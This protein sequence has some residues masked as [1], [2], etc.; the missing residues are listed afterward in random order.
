M[1]KQQLPSS[2]L[3]IVRRLHPVSSVQW[4]F[5]T[6]RPLA[7]LTAI[8]A[9]LVVFGPIHFALQGMAIADYELASAQEDGWAV[10]LQ[11]SGRAR[12]SCCRNA[13]KITLCIGPNT[14]NIKYCRVQS[15]ECVT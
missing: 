3:A 12:G 4:L 5:R 2:Q 1:F 14:F 6:R 7:S 13:S 15:D 9:S 10:G 8:P 11:Q